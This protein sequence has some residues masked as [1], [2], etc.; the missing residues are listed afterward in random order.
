MFYP[1]GTSKIDIQIDLQLDV[2]NVS[3]WFK[4]NRLTANVHKCGSM[5][6]VTHQRLGSDLKLDVKINEL[7]CNL[8]EY[9]Y[10]GLNITNTHYHVVNKKIIMF[11]V[12]TKDMLRRIKQ[13]V[14]QG[15]LSVI[16]FTRLLYSHI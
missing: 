9:D 2:N 14:P 4:D 15:L 3:K 1:N 13:K 11:K 10:L 6:I 5:M 16:I 8:T 12:S 7:V